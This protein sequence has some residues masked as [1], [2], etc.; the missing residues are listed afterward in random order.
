VVEGRQVAVD[1]N[2]VG[3]MKHTGHYGALPVFSKMG[4]PHVYGALRTQCLRSFRV[5]E[6]LFRD[7]DSAAF[8]GLCLKALKYDLLFRT[9][10]VPWTHVEVVIP[11]FL[12]SKSSQ[13]A[14]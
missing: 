9:L 1:C 2:S 7:D 10:C 6:T 5:S 4:R 3:V 11:V 13:F 14:T 8:C 12:N